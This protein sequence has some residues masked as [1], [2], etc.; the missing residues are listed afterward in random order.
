[1]SIQVQGHRACTMDTSKPWCEIA[2]FHTDMIN[3]PMITGYSPKRWRKAD[4]HMEQKAPDNFNV[5][6]F[7]PMIH[8][9]A[10]FNMAN[11]FIGRKIMTN[12]E[13]LETLAPEQYG[14]RKD[15]SAQDQA[16]NKSLIFDVARQTKKPMVLIVNDAKSCYDRIVHV[17]VMLCAR[18][19]GMDLEPILSM[20]TTIQLMAH[21]IHSAY[22]ASLGYGPDDWN[23]PFQGILQGNQFGPPSWAIVSS[24]IFDML[25]AEGYGLRMFSPLSRSK[26][27]LTGLGFVDDTDTPQNGRRPND[28]GKDVIQYAQDTVD[29]WNGGIRTTGGALDPSKTYFYDIDFQWKQGI[30]RY[31]ELDE[32]K[33][34][35][36][37][38]SEGKRVELKQFPVDKGMRTLG[39][40]LAPDGNNKDQVAALR[41]KAEQWAELIIT[42]HLEREEAWRALNTT[43]LKS[44][45]YPLTATTLTQQETTI[46]LPPFDK[47]LCR[48]VA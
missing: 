45:E 17:M 40:I 22:G 20:M 15:K 36:M 6:R 23:V 44:L 42:G 13:K 34:L 27:H 33:K 48:Q 46:F 37:L 7:R 25:R 28:T 18:R 41:E 21:Q 26:I 29:H 8:V 10:D 32:N 12:A 47:Q 31:A 43:I 2:A 30:W 11:G 9:E 14:S 16:L 35:T 38:D 4:D 39:V 19:N 1:M 24:P 5:D 3:I